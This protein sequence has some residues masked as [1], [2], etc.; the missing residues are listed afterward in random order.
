MNR[1]MGALRE[2]VNDKSFS[3]GM[4]SP[5]ET[6]KLE[7]MEGRSRVPSTRNNSNSSPRRIDQGASSST[8]M[9]L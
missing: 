6:G 9:V 5:T 4:T 2:E 7:G 3:L 1:A 8:R